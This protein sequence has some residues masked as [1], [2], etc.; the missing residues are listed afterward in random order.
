MGGC[1]SSG[2]D[3]LFAAGQQ[4]YRDGL[5][6][7]MGALIAA[8]SEVK[9]GFE[10]GS[11]ASSAQSIAGEDDPGW[12]RQVITQALTG[13]GLFDVVNVVVTPPAYAG[14][15]HGYIL[16]QGRLRQDMGGVIDVESAIE[17]VVSSE[18]LPITLTRRDP[19]AVLSVPPGRADIQQPFDTTQTQTGQPG[20]CN[21]DTQSIGDYIACQV[22]ITSPIGG[23][24]A[25]AIGGIAAAGFLAL[26]AI[27]LLKRF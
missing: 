8:G 1:G 16:V 4:A 15:Q 27:V 11:T 25:G 23:I 10:Y 14:L 18:Y 5:R 6:G 19:L 12:I 20:A 7:L 2:I 21:W 9:I 17:Q 26:V 13:T 3:S 22:G 24:G